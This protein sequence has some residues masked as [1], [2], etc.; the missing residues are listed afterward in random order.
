MSVETNTFTLESSNGELTNK[1]INAA[2]GP[3]KL[4][5]GLDANN[6]LTVGGKFT[7]TVKTNGLYAKIDAFVNSTLVSP[8]K[9]LKEN[10]S[11]YAESF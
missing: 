2:K 1:S 6:D 9:K 7:K 3:G 11:R 8:I 4:T 5:I 10:I